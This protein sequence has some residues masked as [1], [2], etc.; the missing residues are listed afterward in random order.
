MKEKK[1]NEQFEGN[2]K[3]AAVTLLLGAASIIVSPD[4]VVH[5]QSLQQ[6]DLMFSQV[7]VGPTIETTICR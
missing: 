1:R 7:A 3:S 6:K 5:G 2:W 4:S